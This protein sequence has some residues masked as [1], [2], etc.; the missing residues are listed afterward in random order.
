MTYVSRKD[1]TLDPCLPSCVQTESFVVSLG[2]PQQQSYVF[3]PTRVYASQISD[4]MSVGANFSS[5]RVQ[6]S[7][8]A[9]DQPVLCA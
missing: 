7:S 4:M 9:F 6:V 2:K 3:M 1:L 8:T 5:T